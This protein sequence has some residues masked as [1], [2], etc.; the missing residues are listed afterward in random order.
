MHRE[1]VQVPT[2]EAESAKHAQFD[3]GSWFLLNEDGSYKYAY[4]PSGF[5]GFYRSSPAFRS[6]LFASL[7]GLLFGY[8]QGVIANV[9]VMKDFV[10][11]WP[12]TLWQK[13]LMSK[14]A[15]YSSH[16]TRTLLTVEYELPCLN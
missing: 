10:S 14:W 3:D 11:R 16:E 9:L 6:A 15:H 12:I 7:G 1:Y 4:G 8:D 5:R 13:G 2:N